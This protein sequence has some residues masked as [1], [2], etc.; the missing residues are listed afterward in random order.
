[1]AVYNPIPSRFGWGTR[2]VPLLRII[3]DPSP[4]D[5]ATS[6]M[7]Q[8]VDVAAYFAYQRHNP[9]SFI[10]RASAQRYF[11]RLGPVLNRKASTHPLGLVML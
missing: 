4:R 7:I 1:M 9:N 8:A 5:S 10:K 11:D 3:E 6:Y 2:N